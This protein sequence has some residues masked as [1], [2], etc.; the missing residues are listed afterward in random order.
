MLSSC[1]DVLFV[2]NKPLNSS[3]YL[4]MVLNF[5]YACLLGHFFRNTLF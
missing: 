3:I 5:K 4:K 2:S 1:L